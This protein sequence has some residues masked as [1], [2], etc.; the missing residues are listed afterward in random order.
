MTIQPIIIYGASDDLV[1]VE[2]PIS[3]EFDCYSYWTGVLEAPDGD[4]LEVY[5]NFGSL[6]WQIMVSASSERGYPSWP[7]QFTERPDR[8][9]DPALKIF[10]PEGTTIKE[11]K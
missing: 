3:E 5:L 11:L 8:E 10:A 4:K 2:G 7:L 9:G 1:E 6:G